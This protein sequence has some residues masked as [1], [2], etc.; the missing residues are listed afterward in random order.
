MMPAKIFERTAAARFWQA[1]PDE[2]LPRLL[3]QQESSANRRLKGDPIP[4]A[5]TRASGE[6]GQQPM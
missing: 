3:T 4:E 5:K 2:R 1:R 6:V